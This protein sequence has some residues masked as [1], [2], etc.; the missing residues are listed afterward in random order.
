ML[1]QAMILVA[2]FSPAP[3]T[4]PPD[5]SISFADERATRRAAIAAMIG[6]MN[7]EPIASTR[8]M[9]ALV[10]VGGW[11]PGTGAGGVAGG[12]AA[13]GGD[14]ADHVAPSQ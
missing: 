5:D 12:G 13:G 1:I 14:D 9:T 8:P 11:A 3:P 6:Q 4:V 2:V 10:E 7:H